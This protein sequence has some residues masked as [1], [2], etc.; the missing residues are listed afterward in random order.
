M[1]EFSGKM[2]DDLKFQ[3][4]SDLTGT[5]QRQTTIGTASSANETQ[6]DVDPVPPPQGS[7]ARAAPSSSS[8]QRQESASVGSLAADGAEQR[9]H[10]APYEPFVAQRLE[11][12]ILA[13][14]YRIIEK[15]GEGG[16][17]SVYLVEHTA[18]EKKMAIKV[19][20]HEYARKT[21][22]KERFLQ[23][24]KA[25]ARIDHENVIEVND[26]GDTPD[27]SVFFAMEYMDGN[28][29]AHAIKVSGAIP[30]SRA[31]GIA[32]QICR[33][34]GAAHANKIIHRD[35]KP[36]N[37]FLIER[38]G[39]A[40]FVK[41]LDFGIAKIGGM[42]DG[43]RRL[44][45]T[46]MIFGT[47]EYMSPE[48]AQGHRPDHRVDIYAVGVILYEMLTGEVPFK[49]DTFMGI[50]TKHIFEPP[51]PPSELRPDLGIP[52]DV[53]A[54]V[55]RALAK[56]KEDRFSSMAEM[57][58]AIVRSSPEG[59][60]FLDEGTGPPARVV[61]PLGSD[62]SLQFSTSLPPLRST[63][64]VPVVRTSAK[65]KVAALIVA[66]ILIGGGGAVA[67]MMGLF[68]GRDRGAATARDIGLVS[69]SSPAADRKTTMDSRPTSLATASDGAP[70][71][72]RGPTLKVEINS[73]PKGAEIQLGESVVGTTPASIELEKGKSVLIKLVRA[74]YHVDSFSVTPMPD[75]RI[76]RRLRRARGQRVGPPAT[77]RPPL[78]KLPWKKVQEKDPDQGKGKIGGQVPSEL[79]D[80]FKERNK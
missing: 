7:P 63:T 30:W 8:G 32:L 59:M 69:D 70:T 28:D 47:P 29:L 31:R 42:S 77:S 12:Q 79:R 68:S 25:A 19:L 61:I 46:G 67:A 38:E 22:L 78:E 23:E 57:G 27:G 34:L 10:A 16:M 41:V 49:A 43:E 2:S 72:Q 73:T 58:S 14:R 18:L 9:K 75:Q 3:P 15:I 60:T 53:Q 55:L 33:A 45:R 20:L 37:V 21:D 6:I 4:G 48:Q 5:E 71:P 74:G 80:P 36:E 51:K 62:P 11:G 56:D 54:I 24:A 13:G 52:A 1:I 40:D 50:L 64:G 76:Y 44:T 66:L 39:R 35:M 65:G 26:F 17:G